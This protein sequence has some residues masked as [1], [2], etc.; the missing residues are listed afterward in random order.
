MA[1]IT[2]RLGSFSVTPRV[3]RLVALC[4][5]SLLAFFVVYALAVQTEIG[6]RADEAALTGGQS[7]PGQAREAADTMLRVVSLGSLAIATVALTALAVLQRRP[8]MILLPAAIV[9]VSLLAT[10]FFKLWLFGRPDL[11]FAPHLDFNSYPSGHTTVFASIGLAA[12]VVAPRRLRT[13]AAFLATGLAAGAG[14]LVVTADWH[15]PSDA[16]GSYLITLAVTA[17]LLALLYSRRPELQTTELRPP[18]AASSPA[19]AR[20]IETVGGLAAVALFVGAILFAAIRYGPDVD[21]NRFH[22]AFLIGSAA[23]VL[24]AGLTVGSLLRALGEPDADP[25]EPGRGP[26]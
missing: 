8:A 15:R 1:A 20:R 22:A 7:A 3:R 5:V 25:A 19:I 11:V 24:V 23:V 13:G 2:T 10:E 21:W 14:V 12:L 9:G 17:G 16:I 26:D 4:A 6:Q 18:G